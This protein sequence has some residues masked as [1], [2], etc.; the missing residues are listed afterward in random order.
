M[1]RHI[2]VLLCILASF[3][4]L[5]LPAQIIT[6]IAG[7]GTS[8][9]SGDGGPATA[10]QLGD[11]YY[12]YPAIDNAGNIY[13]GQLENTI[14]K[15]DPSGIITTIA[16]TNGVL[17]YS[18]DGGPAVNALLYHPTAIAIDNANNIFFA[19][20]NG[21]VIRKIDPSGIISTV[22]GTSLGS[23]GITDG[24]LL[25]NA[26]F[27]A[28][29]AISFDN[30]GNL[31]VSD[32][33][34]DNV[35]KVN[36]A[37]IVTRIAGSSSH[38]YSGDGGP[39]T[40]A[41][42]AYPCKVAADNAGNVYISDAQNHRIRK[43]DALTGI[44]TTIAGNGTNG[45]SGDGGPAV[46][47]EL[48]F[49]GSVVIDNAGNLYIGDYN[50]VIRKI[51]PSGII[52]TYAGTGTF[53]YSGDGGPA[54]A[55]DM[56]FT[57]GRISIDNMGN[58]YAADNYHYVIRKISNCITPTIS[59]QPQSVN[60]CN[61]GNANFSVTATLANSYQWQVDDN[62]GSGW[63]DIT[64]N[65]IYSGVSTSNLSLINA[66]TA[67]NAYRF[68]CV[69]TNACG[70]LPTIPAILTVAT[71]VTPTITIA[72]ATPEI[73]SGN[74]V[75]YT[76]VIQ[77]GGTNP[78]F[79]WQKNGINT[80]T[81]SPVY[82]DNNPA[83]GDMITCTL[84]SN[85]YCVTTP[86][87]TS[88]TIIL[89]VNPILP[90]S[91]SITASAT[92]ACANTPITFNATPTNGGS[93]PTYTW[94]VNG[95]NL[96]VNSAT[97][98]LNPANGGNYFIMAVVGSS[99]GCPSSAVVPSNE[100]DIQVQPNVTPSISIQT[101]TPAVCPQ[102]PVL[103][104]A[105]SVF[106]GSTPFYTWKVNGQVTGTNSDQL[107]V[108]SLV[109]GDEIT[110][111][112]LSNASCLATPNATSNTI[113]MT[114]YDRPNV[115]LNND[116]RI[117]EGGLRI[118]DAGNFTSYLW[119]TGAT[120]RQLAIYSPGVYSVTVTD[121]HNCSNSASTT[122][123]Q[124]LPAPANF[125]PADTSIC[126]YG[127]L[128][129]IPKNIFSNYS[130]NTGELS[131]AITITQAGTYWLRATDNNGC[132]GTDTIY[133]SPK[134]CLEGFFVPTAFT[135]NHDGKNDVLLPRLFGNIKLYDLRI[136]NRWGQ[137][138]FQTTDPHKAWDGNF[139]GMSQDSNVFIWTCTY[140]LEGEERK[141]EK[142]TVVLIR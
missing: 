115:S 23:C 33:G 10:A 111:E 44:I 12:T 17:G 53:G 24:T 106:G 71:P 30:A 104:T 126:S 85:A 94:F 119:N 19:D 57:E 114:V 129:L 110:C 38:G 109:D 32:Y 90:V 96:F 21:F 22:S 65:A 47:A 14:R 61:T 27:N 74:T 7:N 26:H 11:M 82:N 35:Y 89:V 46:N 37:G 112:L 100:I 75:Q 141:I 124:L 3:G 83:D 28:I 6:T 105:T 140:Q 88:N 122:I 113:S 77:S 63:Q 73:C 5:S 2:Y 16:G 101:T 108:N 39:A 48:S 97:Y 123:D 99:V 98:T 51:D 118:L 56:A 52:T 1:T 137:I 132:T 79:Q 117:C 125:L 9:Y 121:N 43:V 31:Y 87:A 103:F 64:D 54:I 42:L 86:M 72:T 66:T 69:L 134:D 120:S 15:I 136:Y 29:S 18:G 41:Q 40:S 68:R 116:P 34:C 107:T 13:I 133:I 20:G 128:Q 127:D 138:V 78:S 84:T 76:A 45:Y 4:C 91:L 139:N 70:N 62:T 36:T 81:N 60:L 80:G 92:T 131:A 135:P 55:A 95:T 130:W 142:G 102:T 67:M 50:M 93:N 58:I 8:G 59:Q 25:S 49:P